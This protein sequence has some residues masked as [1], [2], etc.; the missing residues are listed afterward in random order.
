MMLV[1]I[2]AATKVSLKGAQLSEEK[3][4][5]FRGQCRTM[6]LDMLVK[7]A[8]KHFAMQSFIVH[9]VYHLEI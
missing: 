2:G 8:E 6:V 9:Q 1:D 7:L 4:S 3:K 5:K